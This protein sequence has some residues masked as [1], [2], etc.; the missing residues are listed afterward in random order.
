MRSGRLSHT[1]TKRLSITVLPLSMGMTL[2]YPP[3]WHCEAFPAKNVVQKR[4]PSLRCVSWRALTLMRTRPTTAFIV[5]VAPP[6]GPFMSPPRPV[7]SLEASWATEEPQTVDVNGSW[8]LVVGEPGAGQS[9]SEAACCFFVLGSA[10]VHTILFP[11]KH[12]D[13]DIPHLMSKRTTAWLFRRAMIAAQQTSS[14]VVGTLGCRSETPSRVLAACDS[15]GSPVQ[16]GLK[17][18]N[19]VAPGRGPPATQWDHVNAG[20]DQPLP[21]IPRPVASRRVEDR[22]RAD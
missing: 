4:K 11:S 17:R 20:A 22:A 15:R 5:Q 3:L 12:D 7:A 16:S 19:A 13:Q 14:I 18:R 10:L 6:G 8:P 21:T 1:I 2:R 9:C